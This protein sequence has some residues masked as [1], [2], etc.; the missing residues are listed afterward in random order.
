MAYMWTKEVKQYDLYTPG[1]LE[2]IVSVANTIINAT[3][4]TKCSSHHATN[5]TS[6]CSSDY[7]GNNYGHGGSTGC[8]GDNTAK[9]SSK[10]VN[11]YYSSVNN[12]Y[13][14]CLSRKPSIP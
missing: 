4:P 10:C 11:A 7:S 5:H 3:C 6:D 1:I 2:E 9:Y 13:T 8:N 14:M 12:T